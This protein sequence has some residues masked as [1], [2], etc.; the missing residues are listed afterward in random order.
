[1][2]KDALIDFQQHMIRELNAL[3]L[4]GVSQDTVEVYEYF[5][6]QIDVELEYIEAQETGKELI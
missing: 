2:K 5:L 3:E 1:M 6:W 4:N